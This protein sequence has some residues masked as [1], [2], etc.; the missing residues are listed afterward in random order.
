VRYEDAVFYKNLAPALAFFILFC[1]TCIGTF[2]DLVLKISRKEYRIMFRRYSRPLRG[3]VPCVLIAGVL[4]CG[5]PEK[6]VEEKLSD[7]VLF[8][9]NFEKGV[10]ALSSAGSTLAE[11]DGA[12][13][14][15]HITEGVWETEKTSDG[16]ISFSE[17]S[18]ALIYK[19]K[20]N[21]PYLGRK[22]WAGSVAFWMGVNPETELK[23][24]YPEPFHVG[25]KWDDAVIFVDF[26][27]KH[28]PPALRFGCYPDKLGEV[29]DEMVE[30]R[31]IRVE[32]VNWKS[33][34]WHHIV[35]T[36]E[37]FNSGKA[38]A[39]WALYVDGKERGRKKNLKQ[40][41]SWDLDAQT[42]RFNHYKYQG[43]IDDI[44][45]FDVSLDSKEVAYLF[46]PR[47]PL[48]NLLK[49]DR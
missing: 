2:C 16:Y 14:T 6:A 39:E 32:N 22:P 41:I 42:I 26:D 7:H 8:F 10:D 27:K 35:I 3:I 46:K 24:N 33:S 48:N 15:H 36:W 40:D 19:A 11:I 45:V 1:C 5:G 29:S 18:G 4:S 21:F 17:G 34:E 38:D 30:K 43:K 37:N 31:V 9:S 13:T 44:A 12:L 23:A 20:D 25:K 49:K 47:I 28:G